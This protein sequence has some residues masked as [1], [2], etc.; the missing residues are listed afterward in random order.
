MRAESPMKWK[1]DI[2]IILRK[3]GHSMYMRRG[4]MRPFSN[5]QITSSTRR[6][7]FYLVSPHASTG[8][9]HVLRMSRKRAILIPMTGLGDLRTEHSAPE[10]AW[11]CEDRLFFNNQHWGGSDWRAIELVHTSS[12]SERDRRGA[13]NEVDMKSTRALLSI[14]L[15]PTTT[16]GDAGTQ[17]RMEFQMFLYGG[18]PPAI[19]PM[20]NDGYNRYPQ[21]SS[22]QLKGSYES[23][24]TRCI[25]THQKGSGQARW[26]NTRYQ[27]TNGFSKS[28]SGPVSP[29]KMLP[30]SNA[31]VHDASRPFPSQVLFSP[32][33]HGQMATL[34]TCESFSS[35]DCDLECYQEPQSESFLEAQSQRVLETQSESILEPGD[36]STFAVTRQPS[37][38]VFSHFQGTG[39]SLTEADPP[40]AFAALN[41]ASYDVKNWASDMEDVSRLSSRN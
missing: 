34:S 37:G 3:V 10:Y 15:V 9:E 6:S 29:Q 40:V 5:G 7:T 30:Q 31:S 21:A 24:A 11:D 13:T 36:P 16:D 2:G 26:G 4:N 22:Y 19:Q 12:A 41:L 39:V 33:N 35:S 25:V 18:F 32:Q 1:L 23:R 38:T 27:A 14:R 28:S 20:I 17:F 8:Y